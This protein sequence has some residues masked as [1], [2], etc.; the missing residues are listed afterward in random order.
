MAKRRKRSVRVPEKPDGKRRL[1]R[2][3]EAA[4]YGHFSSRTLFRL[5]RQNVIKTYKQSRPRLTLVDLDSIDAFHDSLP[6]K[7]KAC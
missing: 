3:D 5:I 6:P 7:G 4:A 1:A 2:P